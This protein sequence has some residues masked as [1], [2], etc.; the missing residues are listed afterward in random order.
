MSPMLKCVLRS[1]G[2]TAAALGL[3]HTNGSGSPAKTAYPSND[4]AIYSV[5]Y[6]RSDFS[7][8]ASGATIG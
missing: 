4:M 1:V 5:Y 7:V 2:R 3:A 6:M 8:T